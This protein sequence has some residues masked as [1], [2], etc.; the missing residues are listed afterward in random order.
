MVHKIGKLVA[1]GLLILAASGAQAIP[2]QFFSWSGICMNDPSGECPDNSIATA[3]LEVLGGASVDI[4][5]LT[6]A[7]RVSF[8]YSSPASTAFSGPVSA[9]G[10]N[11]VTGGLPPSGIGPSDFS[12]EFTASTVGAPVYKFETFVGGT[13]IIG[14]GLTPPP[15]PAPGRDAGVSGTWGVVPEPASV[16]LFGLRLVR[17]RV[18]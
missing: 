16:L 18:G 5:V 14:G 10:F 8:T 13:W 17:R 11:A 4:T 9:V 7:D 2:T 15:G 6:L 3:T 1:A 12:V